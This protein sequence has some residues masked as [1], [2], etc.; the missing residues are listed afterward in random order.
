MIENRSEGKKRKIFFVRR[1]KTRRSRVLKS[2]LNV[3]LCFRQHVTMSAVT[4]PTG[5]DSSAA[6]ILRQAN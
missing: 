1:V 6:G 5:V 2:H 4:V 3:F